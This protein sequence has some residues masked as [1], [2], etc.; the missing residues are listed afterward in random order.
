[1]SKLWADLDEK[2]SWS[3]TNKMLQYC[4]EVLKRFGR[5]FFH[6]TEINESFYQKI[7]KK[8]KRT[9]A[10]GSVDQW[11]WHRICIYRVLKKDKVTSTPSSKKKKKS[12]WKEG[13][14]GDSYHADILGIEMSH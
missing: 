2:N 5:L 7:R 6:D 14:Q 4:R 3:P 1:M 11:G 8:K 12:F 10:R 13:S 9:S